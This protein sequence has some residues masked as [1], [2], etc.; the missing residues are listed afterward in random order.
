MTHRS[1]WKLVLA[2]VGVLSLLLGA[3]GDDDD[4]AT[5]GDAETV[6]NDESASDAGDGDVEE[7]A[8]DAVEGEIDAMFDGDCAFL[9]QF[10]G[11]GF[12][13]GF[14]PTAALTGGD[15]GEAFALLAEQFEEVADAA[16]GEIEDSFATLAEGMGS[17]ADAFAGIDFSDPSSIDPE[18]LET[19]EAFEDGPGAEF[20]AA[21]EE[22][23]AWIEENCAVEG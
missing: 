17:F 4:D 15:A 23:S 19:L 13:E 7:A 6:E 22:V 3:C 11:A 9:G 21:S 10:A 12:E 14:D 16:P 20:E 2:L 1:L 18:A 5:S 8:E